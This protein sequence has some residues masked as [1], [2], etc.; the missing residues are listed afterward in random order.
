MN[1]TSSREIRRDELLSRIP[2]FSR[3]DRKQLKKLAGLSVAKTFAPG[4]IIVEEG[5][6]GLGLFALISGSVEVCKD[7]K[8]EKIVLATIGA[9][10]ILGELALVDDNPRSATAVATELTETLLITRSSFQELLLKDP[11][12]AWCIVPTLAERIRELQQRV[13]NN[14]L[15]SE[16]RQADSNAQEQTADDG[17]PADLSQSDQ[18][19]SDLGAE[20]LRS[21][22]ALAMSAITGLE[23][24]LR[25]FE[26]AAQTMARETE[27]RS[28]QAIPRGIFSAAA[29][30]LK[31]AEKV[32]EQM[33]AAFRRHRKRQ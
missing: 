31:E 18:R 24:T 27:L 14:G 7:T 13:I 26:E 21:N 32:P 20:V 17:A 28:V 6:T 9:G 23:A 12:I 5:T 22:Y 19:Y 1:A 11:E 29:A 25:A 8:H 16:P 15:F 10:D 33:V 2:L 4:S 3:L 30:A